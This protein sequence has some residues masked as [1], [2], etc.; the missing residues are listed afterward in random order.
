MDTSHGLVSRIESE[1]GSCDFLASLRKV[2]MKSTS[3]ARLLA[4]R[5]SVVRVVLEHQGVG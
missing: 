2:S 1:S 4:M 3:L 5:S